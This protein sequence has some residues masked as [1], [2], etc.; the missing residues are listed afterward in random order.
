MANSYTQLYIHAVYAV[1]FRDKLLHQNWREEVFRYSSTVISSMKC[2]PL[3]INGVQDHVHLL[4]ALH[5][6]V[7]ISQLI[8][9]VKSNSSRMVNQTFIEDGGF[10]WQEGYSAFTLSKSGISDV[11][12]YIDNQEEH[13]KK[14]TFRTEYIDLLRQNEIPF[15]S[16]YIFDFFD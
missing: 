7:S 4:V 14:Q 6:S 15:D 2:K 16:R 3:A 13:H 12:A 9:K 10:E 8:A 5:P 11:A 1:K